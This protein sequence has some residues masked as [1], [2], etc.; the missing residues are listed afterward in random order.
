MQSLLGQLRHWNKLTPNNPFLYDG[1]VVLTF[2]QA[3]TRALRFAAGL[4]ALGVKPG[5]RVAPIMF[6]GFR[7]YD[8]YY[9]LSAGRF[10][11]VPLNFRLAG[12]ELA[13]QVNDSQAA[14]VIVAPEFYEVITQIKD[15]MPRVQHFLYTGSQSPFEG[16]I[17][18]DSLLE[19][20]PVESEG[21]DENDLFGIYYTGG[22]TGLAKGVMLTHK[23]IVSN[24]FHLASAM[25]LGSDQLALHSAP[26]FHLADGA[27][28]FAIT[29]AGGGHVLVKAFEPTAVLQAVERYKPTS[30]LWVPTMI[31]ML[32]N[33]P[34]V[35]DFDLSSLE[36]VFYGASPISPDLLRKAKAVLDC[37]FAQLYGMTEGGPILT[38]LFPEDH[39][40]G[41]TSPDEQYLLKA[42]G[43]QIIGVD[44]RVVA[45]DGRDVKPGEVG[46]IIAR[47]DNI[48]QGYWNKPEETAGAL[49]DGWYWSKDLARIDKNQYIYV[50]DRAKDM[51]ISG[52]EN[53][54]SVEVED[55]L[56]CHSAVLEA[57]VIG[58]PDK[59]WGEAV[60]AVV[61]LKPGQTAT[62]E[63]LRECCKQRI[64]GYKVPKTVEF[65]EALPKSGAGKI[66]KKNLRKIH[67]QDTERSVG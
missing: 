14:V 64:A 25:R 10:V 12:P 22:T 63:E 54:Y 9:G 20:E 60:T 6:N 39:H 28:N 40:R 66:L 67:W 50:V 31:N 61:A 7:W 65:V 30:T 2:A 27:M 59:D 36:L 53:V 46:E 3:Y 35:A 21:G 24:A 18:Y 48:M 19:A 11:N 57:A 38:I 58:V 45:E 47:G 44:V 49:I 56:M 29:M 51:I 37:D 42:A 1:D 41:L 33:H 23:N 43:R 34:D 32:V 16:A 13:Y 4:K 8:L 17:P 15:Q 26:M 5:T 52:G 55:A 62:A